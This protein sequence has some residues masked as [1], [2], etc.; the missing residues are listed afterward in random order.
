MNKDNAEHA[1]KYMTKQAYD[2]LCGTAP[3]EK[4]QVKDI[5]PAKLAEVTEPV[6]TGN[7]FAAKENP[8]TK[9]VKRKKNEARVSG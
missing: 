8:E 7:Y 1:G 4:I 2:I 6:T 5:Q 3:Q 9:S